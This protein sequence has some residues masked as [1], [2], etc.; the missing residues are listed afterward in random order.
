MSWLFI[1]LAGLFEVVGVAG[2]AK[3]NKK[4]SFKNVAMMACG[5]LISFLFLTLAMEGMAMGTAYAVW[6][7]IGTVG[8]ALVGI[9]FFRESRSML[10]IFFI[11][12]VLFAV[13]GLKLIE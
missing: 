10:R 11:L 13:V 6:T 1:V 9:L 7:G 2:I 8:S 5:F 3:M 4:L 12:L